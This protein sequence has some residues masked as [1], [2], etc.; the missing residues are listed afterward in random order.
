ML[1]HDAAITPLLLLLNI[2]L[3]AKNKRALNFN[4]TSKFYQQRKIR[5]LL[6]I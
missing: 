4:K 5:N 1:A 2:A 3:Y 6:K